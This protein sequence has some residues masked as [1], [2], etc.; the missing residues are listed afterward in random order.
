MI[1][2]QI[3][4]MDGLVQIDANKLA[5]VDEYLQRHGFSHLSAEYYSMVD[6]IHD[7]YINGSIYETDS[8]VLSCIIGNYYNNIGEYDN[9]EKYYMAAIEKG[10]SEAMFNLG[11]Y[12]ENCKRYD[13]MLKYYRM[14]VAKGNT[15]AMISMNRHIRNHNDQF[16]STVTI[17]EIIIS[18]IVISVI[19][20]MKY[21][22]H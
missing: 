15:D 5:Q 16:M 19:I 14:A 3:A 1:K 12:F 2:K 20:T 11:R 21:G 8:N 7:I 10:N 22:K 13:E 17:I 9:M 18:M 6:N 4:T